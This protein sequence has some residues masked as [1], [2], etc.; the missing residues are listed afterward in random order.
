MIRQVCDW[1]IEWDFPT[2]ISIKSSPLFFSPTN[3]PPSLHHGLGLRFPHVGS[4]PCLLTVDTLLLKLHL[5]A[6]QYTLCVYL[7]LSISI[8]LPPSILGNHQELI[9]PDTTNV[10][11]SCKSSQHHRNDKDGPP[12]ITEQKGWLCWLEERHKLKFC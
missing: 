11:Q 5:K 12:N 2:S 3:K 4:L 7:Y 1:Q 9:T 10:K 6:Q 8:Y